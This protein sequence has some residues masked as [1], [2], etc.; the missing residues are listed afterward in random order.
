MTLRKNSVYLVQRVPI[1]PSR[2]YS[3]ESVPNTAVPLVWL[4]LTGLV[5]YRLM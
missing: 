5:I 3:A 1:R 4:R 2:V